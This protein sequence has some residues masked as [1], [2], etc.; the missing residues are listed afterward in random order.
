MTGKY[1]TIVTHVQA[2]SV[3]IIKDMADLYLTNF[4]G[5]SDALFRADLSEKDEAILVFSAGRL[6]GFTTL[7]VFDRYWHGAPIRIVYSGDTIISPEH[8]GQQQLAFAWIG[9]IGEIKRQDPDLPLYW[10]LLVKGHRTFKYLPVFGKSF[11]PHWSIDRNDLKPLADELAL[12]RFGT[13]Y[14]PQTGVVAFPNS[15]GHIKEGI[16]SAT[17]EELTKPATQFFFKRNPGYREG[18]ELVCVCELDLANMKPLTARIF[19]RAFDE[20]LCA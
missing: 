4:D 8:W 20:A 19:Q 5:S 2:L 6:V 7:K 12:E 14:S 15:R 17:S 3:D 10:F 1:E 16:A 11:F 13:D 9:R 18:N